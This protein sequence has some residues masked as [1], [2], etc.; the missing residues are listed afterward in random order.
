M[1]KNLKTIVQLKKTPFFC[2]LGL[3]SKVEAPGCSQSCG[4]EYLWLLSVFLVLL[5]E[6]EKSYWR[7]RTQSDHLTWSH[8][9]L[10]PW[11]PIVDNKKTKKKRLKCD[12][13]EVQS[14][15][16]L[17]ELQSWTK[18]L[19][20]FCIS[21]RFQFIQAQTLPSPHK[22]CWT[23]VSRIFS[24]FQLCIWWGRENY[25]K[26]SKRMHC[27]MMHPEWQKN[28]NIAL[29]FQGLL[30]MNVGS[31][32]SWADYYCFLQEQNINER[33]QWQMLGQLPT[34]PRTKA[35]FTLFFIIADFKRQQFHIFAN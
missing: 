11:R 28:M 33:I 8:P 31:L 25:K 13:P 24:E 18:V 14:R 30:S 10:L 16:K 1:T 19:G 6:R 22:Q 26:I 3:F 2:E 4:S 27:F 20:H 17:N 12:L 9:T 21:G 15:W 23:R 7:Q 32:C 34:E 29:L 35:I 5:I